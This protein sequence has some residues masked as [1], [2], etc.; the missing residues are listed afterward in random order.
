MVVDLATP[1]FRVA[2]SND[3]DTYVPVITLA[4]LDALRRLDEPAGEYG[5]SGGPHQTLV[6]LIRTRPIEGRDGDR[7]ARAHKA[8]RLN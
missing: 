4:D 5:S 6:G 3:F 1:A 7:C 2:L 8:L